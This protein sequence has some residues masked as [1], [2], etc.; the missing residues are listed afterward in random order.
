MIN[1][2][3]IGEPNVG[4]S[5]LLNALVGE[6]VGIVTDLAGTTR[7]QIR[8]FAGGAEIVDTPGMFRGGTLLHKHMRK[9]ISAAVS[10]A[11]ILLYVLDAGK[12]DD[13][14]VTKISN[15]KGKLPVVVA[16]NKCDIVKPDKLFPKLEL[17]KPLDFVKS[18]IPVSAR[19]GYN[20][21]I[22]RRKL[23][24]T[25]ENGEEYTDQS[26]KDMCSEIIR[27]AVIKNTRQEIP[28]GVAVVITKFT[29]RATETE[30]HAE[31]LCE[32]SA[33]KP[34]IIGKGGAL[35]KQIGILARTEIEKLLETHVKL[36]TT[37]IIRPNWKN[38]RDI[39][40]SQL[41]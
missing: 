9:S 10:N 2:A 3:I 26:V 6:N 39:L 8:G 21:D 35:L 28:H 5:S 7:D 13:R 15:Y 27:G 12:F 36:F 31:I 34:I 16:V 20:L 33:H 32:K 4:K 17:L 1:I 41:V 37:V 24:I 11:N 23:G 18:V 40:R 29:E 19:T 14:D 38:D 30:I 22:L 25:E